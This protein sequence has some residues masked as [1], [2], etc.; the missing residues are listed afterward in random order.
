MIVCI[1]KE[2]W[3]TETV[4]NDNG[5]AEEISIFVLKLKNL[6]VM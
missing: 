6:S 5:K 1:S 3:D 4:C 2:S